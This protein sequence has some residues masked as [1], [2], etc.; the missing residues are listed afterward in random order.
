M[1]GINEYFKKVF[2]DKGRGQRA[3]GRWTGRIN[4]AVQRRTQP[5]QKGK[6]KKKEEG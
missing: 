2:I 6:K 4:F 1:P 3:E 5:L